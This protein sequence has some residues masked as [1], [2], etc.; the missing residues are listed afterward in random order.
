MSDLKTRFPLV[1]DKSTK[2]DGIETAAKSAEG[3]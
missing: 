2:L 1:S 3:L